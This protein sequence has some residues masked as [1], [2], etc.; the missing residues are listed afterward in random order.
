MSD[1]RRQFLDGQKGTPAWGALN[2]ALAAAKVLPVPA[3]VKAAS[4]KPAPCSAKIQAEAVESRAAAE[5]RVNQPS[6]S[7]TSATAEAKHIAKMNRLAMAPRDDPTESC[8]GHAKASRRCWYGV[9]DVDP[10]PA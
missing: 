7:I 6:W 4:P 10:R 9:G 8:G 2:D 5:S 3:M 1:A